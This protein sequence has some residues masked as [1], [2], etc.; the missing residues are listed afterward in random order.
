[1]PLWAIQGPSKP[2]LRYYGMIKSVA[3]NV[4]GYAMFS[5]VPYIIDSN[6]LQRIPIKIDNT[7]INADKV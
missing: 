7:G 4:G 5:T 3:G 6:I 1:M 2:F